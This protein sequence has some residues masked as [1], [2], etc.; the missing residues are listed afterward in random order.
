MARMDAARPEN[1]LEGRVKA[2][3]K[4]RYLLEKKRKQLG[5]GAGF[6]RAPSRL[7]SH[8]IVENAREVPTVVT[9]NASVAEKDLT[10]HVSIS[11]SVH[12]SGPE[13]FLDLQDGVDPQSV[14]R[15][16]RN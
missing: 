7:Y 13:V 10:Q 12:E 9:H 5:G 14:D 3:N 2:S 8:R 4:L 1:P 6:S 11:R 16:I 15:V